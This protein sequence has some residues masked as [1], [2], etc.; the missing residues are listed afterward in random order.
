MANNYIDKGYISRSIINNLSFKP[1]T[2]QITVSTHLEAFTLS[3][4]INPVYILKGYAGTG[5][6]SMLSAYVNTLKESSIKFTLL[7]PTGRAAKVLAQYTKYPAHTIHRSIYQFLTNKEGATNIALAYNK[8]KNSIFIIDEASMIGD[9]SQINNSIFNRSSLLDDVMQYVF[10]Q[11][12]NKL[13]LVGDTAQLP[14]VGTSIS[15][16]LDIN[17]LNNS[18]TITSFGFEM[19]EVMRQSLDSSILT[20]ATTLRTKIKNNDTSRPFFDINRNSNDVTI[21]K[22]AGT[23]EE[24]LTEAF[25]VNS[26]ENGIIICRSNKQANIYNNEIRNRILMRETEIDAGDLM[27]VVKN[28]YH[29]LHKDSKAGFIAN[30]DIIKI[31]RYK[32]TDEIYGFRF[33]DVDI[34]LLDYPEEK[35]INLKLLLET[36]TSNSSG[37]SEKN[38]QILFENIE[39]DY[40]E[41]PVRRT[42][43]NKIKA[44]PYFN[45]LHVK[46]S[47]AMTCHKTQ[48]GQWPIVF[49]DK[50]FIKDNIIDSEYL[51]WLYTATTRATK[52]LYLI[53]FEDEYFEEN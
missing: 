31:V 44:N 12:G 46:F 27:M 51:R 28:N 5:K 8:L 22:D 4:K 19:K 10:S 48:G 42:R 1:T 23:F 24:L 38:N 30:G 13:I 14:P 15:P 40:M 2:D 52:N 37:L 3:K 34:Q 20:S 25:T 41:Y 7:A 32:K 26:M 11:S 50:G 47:Y 29:W 35:E 53:G 33:A 36:I 21:I 9:N 49:V 43:I 16:A 17:N 45:A 18:Y 6:T 39:Q